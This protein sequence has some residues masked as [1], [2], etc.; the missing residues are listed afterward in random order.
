FNFVNYVAPSNVSDPITVT[1]TAASVETPS[2]IATTRFVVLPSGAGPNVLALHVDGGPVP[3]HVYP[4]GAYINGVTICNPGNPPANSPVPVCQ[5]I[6]GILVDTG[7]VGLR[8]L[9]S[10]IPLLQL[11]TLTNGDGKTLE[12]CMA[13]P[14]ASYLWGPVAKADVY[15]GGEA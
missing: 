10:A 5:T 2:A 6:D 11:P 8:I 13:M 3:G 4:N 9:Q 7:S 1:V 14:D 15:I 12:N